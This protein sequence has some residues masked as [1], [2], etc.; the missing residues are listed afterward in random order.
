MSGHRMKL[1]IA[2][3]AVSVLGI[4]AGASA[5][6]FEQKSNQGQGVTVR[7]RPLDIAAGARAW[8]FEVSLDTHS[9]ELIDDFTRSAVLI[10]AG[11]VARAPLAWDGTAPGGHHRKGTL[12]FEAIDP[13]P[14]VLEFRLQRPGETAPRVFRWTVR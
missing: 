11:G 2:A 12:R 8:S 13:R 9:Q 1:L 10:D 14:A 6:E 4:A 7:V 5:L 3:L